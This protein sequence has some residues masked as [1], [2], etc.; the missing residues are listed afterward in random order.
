M[1]Y[2]LSANGQPLDPTE[3]HRKVRLLLNAG[4]ATVVRRTPFTIRLTSRT[5][6]YT[7]PATLGVDAGSKTIGLSASTEQKELYASEISLRTDIVDKLSTRREYR[8]AR[9]NRKTRYRKPRFDNRVRSKNKG[10]LA[11]S[12]EAKIAAHLSAVAFVHRILP[13]KEVVVEVASFDTQKLKDDA[14]SGYQYQQGEQLGF[15]N[16]REYV[17]FR[18]GHTCQCCHGKS[19]DKVLNVHHIESRKTGGDAPS[20][21]V[22]LCE[23]CHKAYHAEKVKLNIRRGTSLR[24]AAF[25]GIM[26]WAFYNRL[27]EMYPRV[28]MAY[29]YITKNTRIRHGLEKTH[30][31]DAL[32]IAGHPEAKPAA[33]WFYQKRVRSRNRQLHKANILKGGIRKANQSPKYVFGFRLFDRVQFKGQTCFIFGRRAT[34]RFDLR[35]LDGTKVNPAANHKKITILQKSSNILTERR[36]RGS[37]PELK[38]GVSAA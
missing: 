28:H 23:T 16:V 24:D 30:C 25:M 26:R 7:H 20:N 4:K 37:S 33:E 14:I 11:P 8:R 15:W 29:G 10:W 32:C 35:T 13:I 1:V 38:S 31:V 34:G 5:K 17:L 12:V 6:G 21:L 36:P 22:T 19:K 27:K 9:R 3:N 18:D 2:V